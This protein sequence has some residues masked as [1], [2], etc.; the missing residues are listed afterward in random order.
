MLDSNTI[1]KILRLKSEGHS[2]TQIAAQ[3][4]AGRSTILRYIHD[5][6][7]GRS[8]APRSSKR[9]HKLEFGCAE[10]IQALCEKA[11]CNSAIIARKINQDPEKYGLPSGFDISD[12]SVRR[13]IRENL[14]HL[15]AK[16]EYLPVQPFHTE[17]GAQV[18]I[19][20][21]RAKVQFAGEQNTDSPRE[22]FIFEAVYPWSRKSYAAVMPDMTQASWFNGIMGCFAKFGVPREILCD[23]D[24]SLV[25]RNTRDGVVINA[26]FEWLCKSLGVSIRAAR[27]A[28]PQT[29]GRCER[30]G[31]YVKHTGVI[32]SLIDSNITDEADL[33]KALEKWNAEVADLRTWS[34]NNELKTTAQLY[35]E[36]KP[37]L[38]FPNLAEYVSNCW[39]VRASPSGRVNIFGETI[40]L[41]RVYR[42][43]LLTAAVRINGEYMVC[44]TNGQVICEGRVPKENLNK[45]K[46]DEG[47]SRS[48]AA[49][50]AATASIE[51]DQMADFIEALG[52]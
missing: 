15:V 44:T 19:D 33:H 29:K 26:A 16:P 1:Q 25:L 24:K 37:Y 50:Q 27:P 8:T 4:N 14:R 30:Y 11:R 13:Y 43:A 45:F 7:R 52:D 18:Q 31:R 42:D 39:T 51:N 5:P 10:A 23:N 36:E 6:K 17:P 28:R 32:E 2:I 46:R 12:R 49:A 48:T 21:V 38:H 22:V 40:V 34:V 41:P 9:R 47:A 20:F 3:V 35:E